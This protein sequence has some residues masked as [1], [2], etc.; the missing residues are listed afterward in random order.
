MVASC[1]VTS[2]KVMSCKVVSCKVAIC[3]GIVSV[4]Y[5]GCFLFFLGLSGKG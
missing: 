3:T 4:V 2:C 5:L 1:K